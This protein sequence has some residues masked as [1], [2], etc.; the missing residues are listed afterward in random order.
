MSA[1][2]TLPKEVLAEIANFLDHETLLNFRLVNRNLS[3][4]IHH[5]IAQR[6]F[7]HRAVSINMDSLNILRQISLLKNIAL[8]LPL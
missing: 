8:R 4:T 3:S 2:E 1:L 5:V 7:R 6:F